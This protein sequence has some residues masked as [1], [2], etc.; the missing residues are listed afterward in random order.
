MSEQVSCSLKLICERS[1]F[2]SGQDKYVESDLLDTNVRVVAS[3]LIFL[4][5]F[6]CYCCLS[7][8]SRKFVIKI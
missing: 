5:W 8:T 7:V 4:S 3:F 2:Y 6:C 1:F